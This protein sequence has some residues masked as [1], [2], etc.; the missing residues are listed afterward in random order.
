MSNTKWT[1]LDYIYIYVNIDLYIFIYTYL[2]IV[3]M[4]KSHKWFKIDKDLVRY[5]NTSL[6]TSVFLAF[7]L[8]I[9]LLSS[10]CL[11]RTLGTKPRII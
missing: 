11:T 4:Y 2:K 1:L 8:R 6:S 3:L 10:V 7:I 5:L 9:I